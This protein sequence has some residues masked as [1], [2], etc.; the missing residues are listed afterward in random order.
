M[1][2]PD[3][4]GAEPVAASPTKHSAGGVADSLTPLT[5]GRRGPRRAGHPLSKRGPWS[6]SGKRPEGS[7]SNECF[8]PLQGPAPASGILSPSPSGSSDLPAHLV[9]R[10]RPLSHVFRPRCPP[11][12]LGRSCLRS[13]Q[14]STSECY[15]LHPGG[16]PPCRLSRPK[17]RGRSSWPSRMQRP[18]RIRKPRSP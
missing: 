8:G 5:C 2:V 10:D 12:V 16:M 9:Y 14:R 13:L 18:R 4:I 15:L 17:Q 11:H 3:A 6:G 1:P 7:G